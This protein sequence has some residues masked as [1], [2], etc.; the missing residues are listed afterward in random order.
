MHERNSNHA[1]HVGS[2]NT[3][4]SGMLH[5]HTSPCSNRAVNATQLGLQPFV[6]GA[7]ATE[8]TQPVN[9]L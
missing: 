7:F 8:G 4:R 9:K 1:T 5:R 3:F 6:L 2:S